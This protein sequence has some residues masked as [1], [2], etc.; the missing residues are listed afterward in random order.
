MTEARNGGMPAKLPAPPRVTSDLYI[1]N[2]SGIVTHFNRW[3]PL[4]KVGLVSAA[5]VA[6]TAVAVQLVVVALGIVF[7]STGL[8]AGLAAAAGAAAVFFSQDQDEGRGQDR[9]AMPGG[10]EKDGGDRGEGSS[11]G[12]RRGSRGNGDEGPP[13][14]Y[15]V[16]SSAEDSDCDRDQKKPSRS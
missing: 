4:V 15:S 13:P 3:H 7:S 8:V 14:P 11:D 16:D 10:G 12:R 9:N 1:E 6:G 2:Q 5:A